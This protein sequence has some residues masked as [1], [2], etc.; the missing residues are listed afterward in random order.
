MATP[1]QWH[2][3]AFWSAA[4]TST[5]ATTFG[6]TIGAL[7]ALDRIRGWCAS[8]VLA[9]IGLKTREEDSGACMCLMCLCAFRS[10]TTRVSDSGDAPAWWRQCSVSMS[11]SK[12]ILRTKE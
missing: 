11:E 3:A 7:C 9:F 2:C 12:N 5:S 4:V 6:S 1:R 8:F 10:A